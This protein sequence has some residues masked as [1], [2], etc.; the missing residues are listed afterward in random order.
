MNIEDRC[1]KY[2][3]EYLDFEKDS[4]Y[5]KD[6][7]ATLWSNLLDCYEEGMLEDD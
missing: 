2:N 1:K 5:D 3:D 4:Y 6:E 7:E